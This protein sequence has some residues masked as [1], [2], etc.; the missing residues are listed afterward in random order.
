MKNI[1]RTNLIN[2]INLRKF[3]HLCGKCRNGFL[4]AKPDI[5]YIYDP[6]PFVSED[7]AGDECDYRKAFHQKICC[8]NCS[9]ETL[10]AGFVRYDYESRVI[11]LPDGDVDYWDGLVPTNIV[12]YIE[13][14]LDLIDISY[15]QNAHAQK[16]N[17]SKD[18]AECETTPAEI[19]EI[20]KFE[21][22]L[23][24]SF[25]LYWFD[26]SA[27]ANKIRTTV[28]LLKN[29]IGKTQLKKVP[30]YTEISELLESLLP[31]GN[32]GAHTTGKDITQNDLLDAYDILNSILY[33]YY[34]EHDKYKIDIKGTSDKIKTKFED[35]RNKKK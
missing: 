5:G 22:C 19:V 6:I 33:E 26:E 11:K 32:N 17:L 35:R 27:C 8:D 20:N 14:A 31:I 23:R 15:I 7:E 21:N 30:S 34:G 3:S 13:P 4:R 25:S 9:D 16:K 29:I 18:W 24:K 1:D 10:F 2:P 28:E 12:R